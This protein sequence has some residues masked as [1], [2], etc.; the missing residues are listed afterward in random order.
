LIVAPSSIFFKLLIPNRLKPIPSFFWAKTVLPKCQ[1]D[2]K[3]P[4][5]WSRME[6]LCP[7]KSCQKEESWKR[8]SENPKLRN[9]KKVNTPRK[10]RIR[11]L[12]NKSRTKDPVQPLDHR[13]LQNSIRVLGGGIVP[14]SLVLIGANAGIGKVHADAFRSPFDLDG[15]TDSLCLRERKAKL[16]SNAGRSE[17]ESQNPDCYVP[18][19]TNYASYFSKQIASAKA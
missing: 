4:S 6:Y 12:A 11:T 2:R 8:G 1:M 14:G 15:K 18:F 10:F 7:K 13:R 3:C 5:M 9:P 16:K 17:M 19:E